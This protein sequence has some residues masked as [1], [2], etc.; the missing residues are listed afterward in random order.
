VPMKEI[1]RPTSSLSCLPYN[2]RKLVICQRRSGPFGWKCS[3]PR[4]MMSLQSRLSTACLVCYGTQEPIYKAG[5]SI[6]PTSG[7]FSQRHSRPAYLDSLNYRVTPR[8]VWETRDDSLGD[9]LWE[10]GAIVMYIVTSVRDFVMYSIK[11]HRR[12]S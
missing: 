11:I 2:F 7:Q 3:I 4:L 1:S 6:S 5:S 12:S 10:S 9:G 8:L